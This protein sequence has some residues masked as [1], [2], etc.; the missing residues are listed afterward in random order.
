MKGFRILSFCQQTREIFLDKEQC[1]LPSVSKL[2]S[3]ASSVLIS[4]VPSAEAIRSPEIVLSSGL[5]SGKWKH[6]TVLFLLR[7]LMLFH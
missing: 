5:T 4:L 6:Y 1:I 2:I 3:S 7:E